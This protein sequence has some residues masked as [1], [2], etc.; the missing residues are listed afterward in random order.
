MID[1][2]QLGIVILGARLFPYLI[3]TFDY[4]SL[5]NDVN[6]ISVIPDQLKDAIFKVMYF[7]M[8][9]FNK[10]CILPFP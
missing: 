2:P 7:I 6:F 9:Y 3:G 10:L 5:A 4:L 1:N 8:S